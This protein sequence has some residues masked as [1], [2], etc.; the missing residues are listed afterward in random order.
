METWKYIEGTHYQVSDEGRIRRVFIQERTIK[1]YGTPYRYLKLQRRKGRGT[2]YFG[3]MLGGKNGCYK[4]VHRLV[5]Q[6]FIPNPLNLPQV[7]HIN[8]NGLDNRVDN[9]EWCTNR[10]NALHAKE[11]GLTNPY[12]K[13]KPV[14]CKELDKEFGSS[15]EAADFINRTKYQDSRRIKSIA[16]NIRACVYGKRRKAYGYTWEQL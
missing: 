1:K 12:H 13:G 7:N 2:D 14:R 15:F 8:G 6:A 16:C 9:L 3:V 11:N 4:L 5:A 10:Q